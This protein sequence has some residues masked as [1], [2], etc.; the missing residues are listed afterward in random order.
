MLLL[1]LLGELPP[2]LHL[3][4]GKAFYVEPNS[5]AGAQAEQPRGTK[6]LQQP[7]V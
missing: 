4:T 6:A 7:Q 3:E 5:E 2:A 1:L